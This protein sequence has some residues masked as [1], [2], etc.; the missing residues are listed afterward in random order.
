MSES[1]SVEETIKATLSPFWKRLIAWLIDQIVISL[2]V[3][4]VLYFSG[5]IPESLSQIYQTSV[6]LNISQTIILLNIAYFTILEGYTGQTLGKKV[7]SIIVF[8]EEKGT[9]VGFTRALFRRIGLIIPLLSILDAATILFTSKNQRIFDILAGTLVV[10]E[11]YQDTAGK[12]LRGEDIADSIK[13]EQIVKEEPVLGEKKQ[14]KMLEKLKVK[15]NELEKRF[16]NE[17]IEGKEYRSLKSKY[18]SRIHD[19]EEK[20]GVEKKQE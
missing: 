8:E 1:Y 6:M 10:E 15:K 13:E 4:V 7:L 12:I 16:K 9:K 18:D 3:L 2:G 14:K 20:I 11:K 17:E 19:L 5:E